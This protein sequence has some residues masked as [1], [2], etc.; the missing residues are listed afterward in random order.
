MKSPY[1]HHEQYLGASDAVSVVVLREVK[2]K[3]GERN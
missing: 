1:V 2:N 3:M